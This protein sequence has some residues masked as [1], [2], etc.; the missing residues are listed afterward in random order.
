MHAIVCVCLNELHPTGLVHVGP[1]ANSFSICRRKKG[2]YCCNSAGLSL[3][4]DIRK[5]DCTHKVLFQRLLGPLKCFAKASRSPTHTPLCGC[6]HARHRQPRQEHY[7]VECLP[8]DKPTDEE[9]EGF[10]PL[11]LQSL[12]NQ[13]YLLS[14]SHPDQTYWSLI[15]FSI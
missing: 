14:H 8:K 6:C 2:K 11:T 4:Y 15:Q 12:D 1:V 3:W 5:L 10:E 13:L 7:R 9:G